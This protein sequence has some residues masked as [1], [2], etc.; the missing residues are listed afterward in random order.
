MDAMGAG[1]EDGWPEL[2]AGHKLPTG[3]ADSRKLVCRGCIAEPFVLQAVRDTVDSGVCGYC[4]SSAGPFREDGAV[5]E[6]VYRCLCQEYCDPTKEPFWTGWNDLERLSICVMYTMTVLREA[7][8]PFGDAT[9]V[10]SAFGAAVGHCWY[11]SG[12][13]AAPYEA[14]V[15]WRWDDFV[16]RLQ[17]G[18]RF[19]SWLPDPVTGH[20]DPQSLLD[21]LGELANDTASGYLK[22]LSADEVLHRARWHETDH[23][24]D[25]D[26]LGSPCP[27]IA[28]PQRM[29]AAGVSCFYA[30]QEPTTAIKEVARETPG[31]TSVGT[32]RTKQ[33]LTFADFAPAP[34]MPSLYNYPASQ[35][36]PDIVFL[37]EFIKR[38][39]QSPDESRGDANEYLGTQVLAEYFRYFMPV[40]GKH[41][42]DAIRYPSTRCPGGV[43][44][45][46]FGRPD[47]DDPPVVDYISVEHL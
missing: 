7:G 43:N 25:A 41:G 20:V 32:W 36:R 10:A 34:E 42:I 5:F 8:E 40:D 33:P 31:R 27:A 28:S 24:T 19:L 23:F 18:P 12:S 22:T 30:A 39:S 9:E 14:H 44:W 16:A 38:I 15:L 46:L 29:S 47:H 11:R 45:V 13:E 37:R 1:S 21:Y 17:S 3:F 35:Q 2:P 26:E 6:Y 4:G